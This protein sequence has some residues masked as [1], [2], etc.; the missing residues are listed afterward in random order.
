MQI[1][2]PLLRTAA[3][4]MAIPSIEALADAQNVAVAIST[5]TPVTMQATLEAPPARNMLTGRLEPTRSSRRCEH[6]AGALTPGNA[7]PPPLLASRHA[8]FWR[9]SAK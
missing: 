9:P 3:C 6:A 8:R 1:P 7:L 4:A 2:K 5:L